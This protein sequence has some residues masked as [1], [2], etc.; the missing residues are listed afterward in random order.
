MEGSG[1]TRGTQAAA[2]PVRSLC[3]GAGGHSAGYRAGSLPSHAG[4]T[5]HVANAVERA[6]E[7]AVAAR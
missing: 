6:V 2:V 5:G 3:D 7:G 1:R 4:I